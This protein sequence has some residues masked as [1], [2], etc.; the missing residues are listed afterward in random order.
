M[1]A[2]W[3]GLAVSGV[4]LGGA[5]GRCGPGSASPDAPD[6]MRANEAGASDASVR[7]GAADADASD[8]SDASAKPACGPTRLQPDACV[9]SHADLDLDH[10]AVV[11]WFQARDVATEE[12]WFENCREVLFGSDATHL[13]VCNK[14]TPRAMDPE[15]GIDGP[16]EHLYELEVLAARGKRRV[17]LL[18]VPFGMSTNESNYDEFSKMLF[19][20]RYAV[21]GP[22]GTFDILASPEECRAALGMLKPYFAA[23]DE[24]MRSYGSIPKDLLRQLTRAYE[25][26]RA[27]DAERI[28]AICR[29]A[30]RYALGRDGRLAKGAK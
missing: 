16:V 29:T 30:G 8:A 4:L 12:S 6:A 14:M 9:S 28:T 3:Y 18:R 23:H 5:C 2:A 20:A 24:E 27:A 1:R 11:A 15:M 10:A 25:L 19:S 17:E 7:D 21:D 13:L 26:E 22:A